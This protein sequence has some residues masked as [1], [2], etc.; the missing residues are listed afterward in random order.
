MRGFSALAALALLVLFS[1]DADA[2]SWRSRNSG[3]AYRTT[4]P[5]Y[6]TASPTYR[7]ASATVSQTRNVGGYASPAA[8]AEAKASRCAAAGVMAHLGGGYGGGSAEGV[9]RGPTPAAALA[10]CC[11]TGQRPLLASA[12]RQGRDGS[13][14]AVKIFR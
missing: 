4:S 7:T 2:R 13:W 8:A 10:N 9:G 6:R 1:A 11:F 3:P 14:Y 12:V 5:T